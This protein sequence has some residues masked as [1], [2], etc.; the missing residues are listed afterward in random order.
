[1]YTTPLLQRSHMPMSVQ[2]SVTDVAEMFHACSATN[3]HFQ[4]TT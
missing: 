3:V 4:R 1:M 2:M